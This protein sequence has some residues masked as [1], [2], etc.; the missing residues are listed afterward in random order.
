MK[1]VKTNKD[2]RQCLE[3][4]AIHTLDIILF[5]EKAFK[6][7]FHS[8]SIDYRSEGNQMMLI[9]KTKWVVHRMTQADEIQCGY[10]A[11]NALEYFQKNS[12]KKLHF[13]RGRT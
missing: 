13:Y 6:F 7:N 11:V 3:A 5:S 8:G 12:P 1:E 2:K 4:I 9:A 10:A